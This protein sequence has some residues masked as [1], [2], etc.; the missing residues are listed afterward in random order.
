MIRIAVVAALL[1]A[2]CAAKK[3]AVVDPVQAP[4]EIRYQTPKQPI[5]N[6]YFNFDVD[7]L[8]RAPLG[9]LKRLVAW[10]SRTGTPLVCTGYA[11]TVGTEEYNAGLSF[12]RAV[13]VASVVPCTVVTGGET[14]M[15][16]REA[17]N[18]RVTI[19]HDEAH[20]KNK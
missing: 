1:I 3:P 20:P 17:N 15:F 9:A 5:S 6:V 19:L 16:G 7:T 10:Q 8:N 12:H 2:G 4:K 13:A 14:D 11:D 18:R